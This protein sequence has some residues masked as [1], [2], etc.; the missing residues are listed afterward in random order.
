MNWEAIGAVAELLGAIGV[1]ASLVYL[2]GQIRHSRNQME[3]NTRAT[4]ASA[5]QQFEHSLSERAM[6]QVVVPG[7]ARIVLLGMSDLEQLNEEEMR[8][9]STWEYNQ[10]RGFD[11]AYYQY[12][13]GMFDEGRWLMSLGELKWNMDQ[14]GVVAMWDELRKTLSAEFVT[15]V[16]GI[17]ADER[18]RE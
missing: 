10:M 4:Q 1:I 18:N 7:L 16:D 5:Y 15:L 9:F 14:P 3:Q 6:T 17:L 11:N 12:Q 13:L 2:A 8:Q